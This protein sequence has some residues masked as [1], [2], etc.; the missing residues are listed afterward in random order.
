MKIY[1]DNNYDYSRI[2]FCCLK[3]ANA[4]MQIKN[5]KIRLQSG[6]NP[7]VSFKGYIIQYCPFC[8]AKIEGLKMGV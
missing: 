4:M 3:M 1:L 5:A 8:G 6:I 7:I 2:D